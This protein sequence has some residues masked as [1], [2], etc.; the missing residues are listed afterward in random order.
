MHSSDHRLDEG[1][2]SLVHRLDSSNTSRMKT[3]AEALAAWL[4]QQHREKAALVAM[5][6]AIAA[7]SSAEAIMTQD[8][9]VR[10]KAVDCGEPVGWKIALATPVMQAMVG[11]DAPI[12]GRLHAK[13]VIESPAKTEY[14]GYGRLLVEF[15]IAVRLGADLKPPRGRGTSRHDRYSVLEAVDA[16]APAMEIADDRMADYEQMVHHG[17]QLLADNAWNEGAIIGRWRRDWRSLGS[18]NEGLGSLSGIAKINDEIVGSGFGRD[19]MGH[20][21][22]AL[23]WLANE[24]NDRGRYLCKGEIA[25]LGS[26]VRSKFPKLGDRLQFQL[27]G[28]EPIMLRIH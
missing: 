17:L 5:P 23:A 14:S 8:A 24:A 1:I 28:F 25:I 19:L 16:L 4:V 9:F 13:Q 20:P 18:A 27:E 22:E 2:Y 7:R 3:K 21:L 12:A 10:L 11:L 26:L 15:E 6:E